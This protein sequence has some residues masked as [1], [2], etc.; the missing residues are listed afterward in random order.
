MFDVYS[1]VDTC[2]DS[3]LFLLLIGRFLVVN[4]L[5]QF[6]HAPLCNLMPER[7]FHIASFVFP[8]CARC[9]GLV[10]GTIGCSISQAFGGCFILPVIV[11]IILALLLP[12]DW[13]V[14][15]LGILESTNTRRFVTG[16]LFSVALAPRVLT[17]NL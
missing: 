15:S 14:Q 3:A 1:D 7:A 8:L 2:A 10:V 4:R 9:T 12:I 5:K 16:F 6:G 13:I 11:S 17:V